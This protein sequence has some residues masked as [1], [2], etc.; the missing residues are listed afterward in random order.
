MIQLKKFSYSYPRSD[1]QALREI[2]LD[3]QDGEFLLVTGP[4]GSG[5]SSLG[6]ALNGLIPHYYGGEVS[7]SIRIFG[8]N[9][10]AESIAELAKQVGI[11]FQDPE[12]QLITLDVTHEIAF[13]MENLGFP[14]ELIMQRLNETL[15][16]LNIIHLKN[17][18]LSELSGGEKQKIAIAAVLALHPRVLVLDEPTSE[19]D[20]VTAEDLLQVLVHLNRELKICVILIEHRLERVLGYADRLLVM[21]GGRII[22][23]GSPRSVITDNFELL[24]KNGIGIPPVSRLA[25]RLN[26]K[27]VSNW[28]L[29]LTLQEGIGFFGKQS[30][31]ESGG[32][33]LPAPGD[34]TPELVKIKNL[35]Y[36]YDG[37]S[38][39]LQNINL[40][41]NAGEFLALM[42]E[43]GSGKTTLA[44]N[45]NGLLNPASGSVEICGVDTCESSVAQL[46]RYIGYVF[47]NPNLHL[48]TDTVAEEISFTMKNLHFPA[49]EMKKQLESMLA[50]F[51]LVSS[52]G[53]YPRALS[54]GEKQRVALASVQAAAPKVLILDEPTRG[55]EYGLKKKLMEYLADYCRQGNAVILITHDVETV[56]EYARRVL[57][58]DDG[59]I[60]ACGE[61]HDVLSRSAIFCPQINRL[62]AN[63]QNNRLPDNVLTV[64]EALE[65]IQ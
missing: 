64:G 62:F 38:P 13:G 44:K 16:W 56:A 54:G 40:A 10:L 47:Q 27:A 65:I 63:L 39:V 26:G 43:N 17:R 49:D 60:V 30:F 33:G 8:M 37:G 34:S 59:K 29:P 50:A 51:G 58:L 36:Q 11:V 28:E 24:E 5:K 3:I 18:R 7:G 45:I 25:Y 55:M 20:P 35:S 19:L 46:A 4:S 42:G 31:D 53:N 57:I 14:R 32:L 48:F 61:K 2:D 22:A 1:Q 15:H 6:R 52:R 41:I 9:P 21:A 12:N 23:D